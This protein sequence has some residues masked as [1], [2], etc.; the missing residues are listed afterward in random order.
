MKNNCQNV[1]QKLLV[2]FDV[3]FVCFFN[4]RDIHIFLMKKIL[5]KIIET[6]GFCEKRET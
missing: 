3:S 5:A 2:L 6:M 1:D 4:Q